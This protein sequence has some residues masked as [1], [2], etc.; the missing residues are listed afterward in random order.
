MAQL[1]PVA[2]ASTAC[3]RKRESR[4]TS[5]ATSVRAERLVCDMHTSNSKVYT[6]KAVQRAPEVQLTVSHVLKLQ[7]MPAPRLHAF[8]GLR[9]VDLDYVAGSS[10][11]LYL[12]LQ[13]KHEDAEEYMS[14]ALSEA[15]KGFGS[16]HPRTAEARQNLADHYGVMHK[17]D[18][19][20]PL[21]IEVGTVLRFAS[22]QA[23]VSACE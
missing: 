13:Q 8:E 14:L 10:H 3:L 7:C 15:I 9:A 2:G 22:S 4:R 1:L 20:I 18:L 21:Y 11:S 6:D 23:V 16:D 5:P 17:Y 12:C 19:A